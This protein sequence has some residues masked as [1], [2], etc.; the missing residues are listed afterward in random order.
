VVL[1]SQIVRLP[2][3]GQCA[4]GAAT[5]S[6]SIDAVNG[7]PPGT[8]WPASP[9]SATQLSRL[10]TIALGVATDGSAAAIERARTVIERLAPGIRGPA[11]IDEN[12]VNAARQAQQY[13]Q[14]AEVVILASL[15][16]AGCSLAVSVGGGLSERRRPF[17]LLRLSGVPLAALRRVVLWESVVPLLAAAAVAVAAG[18][19]AAELFL[20]SQLGYAIQAPSLEYYVV[21][22]GGLVAALAIL[23]STMPLLRRL[24]GPEMARNG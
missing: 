20:R 16:V 2:A 19:G 8:V 4:A 7:N 11:T 1:C 5:G 12:N 17:S 6:I 9:I 3:W 23:A 18:F 10:P 15:P 22:A 14:L 21:L 13:Q 24:T